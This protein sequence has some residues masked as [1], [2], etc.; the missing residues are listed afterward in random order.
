MQQL[1]VDSF[2]MLA[3]LTA[4]GLLLMSH[5]HMPHFLPVYPSHSLEAILLL[6]L[7]WGLNSGFHGFKTGA[8]PLEPHLKILAALLRQESHLLPNLG[9]PRGCAYTNFPIYLLT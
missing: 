7:D 5:L 9:F 8:S 2:Q 4:R 3:G 1:N 6:L